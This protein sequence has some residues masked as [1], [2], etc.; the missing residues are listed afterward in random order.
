[1]QTEYSV[2]GYR[3]DVYLHDYKLV[4]EADEFGHD[5]RSIDYEIQRQ[6]AKEK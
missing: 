2:L 1:M 3:L 4:I 5:D 6:K